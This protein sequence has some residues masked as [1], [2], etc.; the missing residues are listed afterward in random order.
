MAVADPVELAQMI[1]L[2]TPTINANVFQT[3]LVKNVVLMVVEDLV[4]LVV[5]VILVSP[6]LANAKLTALENNAV[7]MVAVDPVDLVLT[8]KLAELLIHASVPLIVLANNVVQMAV[9]AH[10]VPVQEVNLVR[11]M[12]NVNAHQTAQQELIVVLM[13]VVVLVDHVELASHAVTDLANVSQIVMD[14]LV[15]LMAVVALVDP[16]QQGKLVTLTTIA[17]VAHLWTV[18]ETKS[19]QITTIFVL[20]LFHPLKLPLLHWVTHYL[21]KLMLKRGLIP[22]RMDIVVMEME[23]T[24]IT[25][26]VMLLV[27]SSLLLATLI[28]LGNLKKLIIH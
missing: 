7:Q 27:T 10:V 2:A 1:K 21:L 19:F 12:V 14:K 3:V 17:L 8:V 25:E 22:A 26:L 13:A 28:T 24:F 9:V 4:V 6:T 18:L 11:L 20:M 16:V 23:K 15:V 5:L